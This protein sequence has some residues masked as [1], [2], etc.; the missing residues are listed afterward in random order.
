[1]IELY[2]KAGLRKYLTQDERQ[3]FI[4]AADAAPRDVRTFCYV[5]VYTGCRITEALELTDQRVDF[6]NGCLTFRTIKKRGETPIYRSVPVPPALLDLLD[7]VHGIK[8][9]QTN[10]K[11]WRWGRSTAWRRVKEIMERAGIAGDHA[12]PKGLRHS[13]GVHAVL[14]NV[15]LNTLQKWLGHSD[16][17]TTAIYASV[18]GQEERQIAARMWG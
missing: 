8:E 17:S 5:L 16:M 10:G 13:F 14:S 7:M 9:K 11:L 1:M 3:A 15:P 12:S 4:K 6:A 18:I 2:T